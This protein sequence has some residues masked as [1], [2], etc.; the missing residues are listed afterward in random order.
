MKRS[1][2][3]LLFAAIGAYLIFEA[4]SR[5]PD[6]A[7][8][9]LPDHTPLATRHGNDHWSDDKLRVFSALPDGVIIPKGWQAVGADQVT[10]TCALFPRHQS[11]VFIKPEFW[12]ID[13]IKDAKAGVDIRRIALKS[14]S[15][16]DLHTIDQRIADTFTNVSSVFPL[17]FT[18]AQKAVPHDVLVTTSIAGDNKTDATRIYP[19]PGPNL[20]S[21]FYDLNSN[22]G[23]DLFI[24]AIAHV[25]NKQRPRPEVAPTEDHLPK[26]EYREFVASWAELAFNHDHVYLRKRV[27]F[28]TRQNKLLTDTK[29]DTWPTYSALKAIKGLPGP[30]GIP[31]QNDPA[32]IEYAHYYQSPLILL[33]VDGLLSIYAP[34]LTVKMIL[35]D[36]HKGK[37]PGLLSSF[38]TYL[39]LRYKRIE[40]WL[41]GTAPI[42]EKLIN[43][44]L[45][46]LHSGFNEVPH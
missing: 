3:A 45:I 33:A 25:Y 37:S 1:L 42:P 20:S 10:Q 41:N 44:G 15:E 30:F 18:K 2:L 40:T 24:H 46:R 43:R 21:L 19:A 39:P 6:F 7:C 38:K 32:A 11:V 26:V 29:P 22:R 35:Q 9:P 5:T 36:I 16:S 12:R 34:D 8:V 13:T 14:T 31:P 4:T 17:G 28:L 23:E 27:N